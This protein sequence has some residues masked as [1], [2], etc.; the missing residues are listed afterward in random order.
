MDK[1][2][3]LRREI[4]DID[5]RIIEQLASR[6][7]LIYQVVNEKKIHNESIR[8]P[9]REEE[10]L[11][12][13]IGLGKIKGL[14]AHFVTK[15]FHEIIDDSLRSQEYVLLNG[16]RTKS[17][18]I[19][20]AYQGIEGA[21]SQIAAKRFFS[22]NL[23]T[24]E[25]VGCLTFE[26]TIEAVQ[27]GRTDYGFLPIENTTAGS[28]N[29]VYDL[30]SRASLS[31]VGEEILPV[32]HCL[33]A[34]EDVPLNRIRRILSHPEA[35]AQCSKFLSELEDCRS[36]YYTDTAMAVQKVKEDRD[37]SQAA[38]ASEEAGKKYG[39]EVIRRNLADQRDNY[40]RFL[41]V[42]TKPIHVDKRIP[43]KTSLI[44]A[45]SHVAGALLRALNALHRH[46]INMTKLESRPRPGTPFQYL[47][48]LDFEGNR[49]ADHVQ[50]A[51]EELRAETTFLKVL[52]S[53]PMQERSKTA[54][55]LAAYLTRLEEDSKTSL[56]NAASRMAS[57]VSYRLA[58]RI[59]KSR[60]T[61]IEVKGVPIGGEHFA[62]I[63]GPSVVESHEQVYACARQVKEAG[64]RI[65]RGG[66]FKPR[67]SPQG[68]QGL[69]FEGLL[70]LAEAGRD[71]DLPIVTEVLSPD[72]VE[73]V[74]E[75]SDILQIGARNMQ[76]FSLLKAVGQ[77]DC[78]AILKR[79]MMATLD[80]FLNAAEYILGHGNQQ[81]ILCERG[82]RTFETSTRSTLDLGAIPILKRLTHLPI[83]VDPSHAAGQRDL[84]P[85]LALAAYAVGP[86]GLMVEIHPKPEEALS[87][88]PQALRFPEFADLMRII[89][90]KIVEIQKQGTQESDKI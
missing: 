36:E 77:I 30:L 84:V 55:P 11:S 3:E 82:I 66:C 64:G 49:A 6:R 7:K 39:L 79:G 72:D 22:R 68:F 86:H 54:P 70:L 88:G 57:T 20:V 33:L 41:V 59:T 78:P 63:A 56:S 14:D 69:G 10:I 74:A 25:L 15:V 42:A 46:K 32:E 65:L 34:L 58:S 17:D 48:Y 28:I 53:Y 18:V 31:I 61:T 44:I 37:L 45:T 8:N 62:M 67:M 80:E 27:K 89:N 90:A 40:T 76:N 47:F 43:C 87:D 83:I 9:H 24:T 29:K 12:R 73:K 60:D 75:L 2:A 85:S 71:F 52:G 50:K 23:D 26:E 21:Y 19:R 16:D 1:L 5:S 81:V 13:L 38:I 4:D 35:L 51:L